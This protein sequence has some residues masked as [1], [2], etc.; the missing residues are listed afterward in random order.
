MPFSGTST[1]LVVQPLAFFAL[2]LV[3]YSLVEILARTF[4]AMR[5]VRIPVGAGIL[6]MIINVILSVILTPRIGYTGLALSLSLSTAIE[7]LIL[8]AAL[9]WRLGRFDATFGIWFAK[10]GVATG[11]MACLSF[12]MSDHL[13]GM[14]ASGASRDRP[15]SRF[16]QRQQPLR[17]IL[18]ATPGAKLPFVVDMTSTSKRSL[19]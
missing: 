9:N 18:A 3:F 16:I 13:N 19:S 15:N 11:L 14:L 1:A 10:V 4:Y 7:A 17:P 8:I 12:V 2:A 6:I 5:N